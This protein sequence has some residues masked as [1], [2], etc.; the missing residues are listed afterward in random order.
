MP[1]HE[2]RE[3]FR[4]DD[5]VYF[6]YKVVAAGE[7]CTDLSLKN[8]LLGEKGQIY[9]EMANYF[10]DIEYELAEISQTLSLKE[11][12]LAHY[13]NLLNAKID[14]VSNQI[15]MG[16]KIQMHKVN[17]SLGGMSFQTPEQIKEK[18]LLK[19]VLYTKPKMIPILVDAQVVFC[20]YQKD[21]QYRISVSF[22]NL[23]MEHEQ[24]LSQHI[25]LV[26]VKS[27]AV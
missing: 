3:H 10:Q 20:Q 1:V 18:S 4:I 8:Q 21:G 14:Y 13:L 27:R 9:M 24:L 5:R 23:S 16:A 25:L 22:E 6:D 11:P 17:L 19:I 12:A 15:M 26:Q 7:Y 2:R